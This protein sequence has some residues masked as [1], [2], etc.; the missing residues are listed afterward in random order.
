M[1][2]SYSQF[3]W[4]FEVFDSGSKQNNKLPFKD[5]GIQYIATLRAG[6]STADELAAEGC[7]SNVV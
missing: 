2:L 1:S 6:V 4:G 3:V 5:D 7:V